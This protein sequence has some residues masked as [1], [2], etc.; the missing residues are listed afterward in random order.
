MTYKGSCEHH[1]HLVRSLTRELILCEPCITSFN[2][3]HIE[4]CRIPKAP[5]IE[6][7]IP[8]PMKS[9]ALRTNTT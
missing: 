7:Q 4:R 3:A 8:I 1:E 6:A 5:N 9:D 2:A